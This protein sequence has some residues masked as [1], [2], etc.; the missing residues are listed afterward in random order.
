VFVIV[1][2]SGLGQWFFM[3]LQIVTVLLELDI[4]FAVDALN[5]RVARHSR[6][7]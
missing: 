5:T 6:T 4:R 1:Y 7:V 2:T 3:L